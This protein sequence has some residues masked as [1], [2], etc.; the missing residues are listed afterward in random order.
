LS[1]KITAYHYNNTAYNVQRTPQT[2]L[3]NIDITMKHIELRVMK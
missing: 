2:A 3:H 1:S